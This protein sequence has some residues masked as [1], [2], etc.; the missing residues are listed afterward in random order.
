MRVRLRLGGLGVAVA[1]ADR[2]PV[3]DRVVLKEG[4]KAQAD[5]V[6]LWEGGSV[7]ERVSAA[8]ADFESDLEGVD[9]VAGARSVAV[10]EARAVAEREGVGTGLGVGLQGTVP[11]W[12]AVAVSCTDREALREVTSEG[13]SARLCVP[14]RP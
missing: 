2:L 12:V 9:A 13:V 1:L 14:E 6:P 8:V 5:S 4:V 3:S 10:R 11:V 7:G